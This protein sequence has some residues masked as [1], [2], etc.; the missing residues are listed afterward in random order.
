MANTLTG[1]WFYV[2][3]ATFV[4]GFLWLS[5]LFMNRGLIP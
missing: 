4:A 3:L 2:T 1:R 5:V